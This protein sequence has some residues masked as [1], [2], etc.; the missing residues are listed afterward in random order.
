VHPCPSVANFQVQFMRFPLPTL[1][2]RSAAGTRF[3]IQ[4]T[5]VAV[6]AVEAPRTMGNLNLICCKV[7]HLYSPV[8]S[9]SR[10]SF[11][12]L[13]PLAY[14]K[15]PLHTYVSAQGLIISEAFLAVAC[16][17]AVLRSRT[18]TPE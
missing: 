12:S 10:P 15:K 3:A 2:P 13:T 14:L 8:H 7:R 5:A 18:T 1:A 16:K 4:T 11:G 17:S 9:T 6:T